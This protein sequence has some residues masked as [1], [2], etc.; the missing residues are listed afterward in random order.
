MAIPKSEV[1]VLSQYID[2]ENAWYR[3]RAGQRVHYLTIHSDVFDDDT[4]SRPYLLVPKL[5]ELPDSPWTTMVISRDKH[6][7]LISVIS[8]DP[9]PGI[10]ATWHERRVDVLSLKRTRRL[11]SGVHEVKYDGISAISKIAC[12][13]W[14]IA[15][16]ERETW[17]YSILA[18]H[19]QQ[20]PQEPPIAPAFLGHVTENGRVVGLLLQKVDGLSACDSDL[21]SCEALLR[22]L[23]RLGLVHGDVNRHNFLVDQDSGGGVH[24]VD[25]EHAS[26]FDEEMARAEL[27]SL[28]VELTEETGRGASVVLTADS[29]DA[30]A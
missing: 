7:S 20:Y 1:E 12:F 10:R 8:E 4:I 5:P 24:L 13:E 17:A 16:I 21:A 9:L 22:R 14:D 19:Q 30:K 25:F 15:R 28:P 6:G 3:L 26:W 29:V 11:R 27:L 18:Q 2:D 23:H